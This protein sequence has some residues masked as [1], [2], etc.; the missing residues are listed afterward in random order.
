MIEVDSKEAVDIDYSEKFLIAE[1]LFDF[2]FNNV[3]GEDIG[4]YHQLINRLAGENITP[5]SSICHISYDFDGVIGN[6][7]PTM[8]AAWDKIN[9][10]FGLTV[11]FKDYALH[12]GIDFLEILNRLQVKKELHRKIQSRYISYSKEFLDL[13]NLYDGTRSTL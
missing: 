3:M 4:N 9:A 12:L 11:E 8:N 7:L 5:L 10:E 13:S 2:S 1:R 6:S